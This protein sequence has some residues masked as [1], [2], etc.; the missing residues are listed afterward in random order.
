[1][2]SLIHRWRDVKLRAFDNAKHRTYVDLKASRA[3]LIFFLYSNTFFPPLKKFTLSCP[4]V[5]LFNSTVIYAKNMAVTLMKLFDCSLTVVFLNLILKFKSL[6]YV[7]DPQEQ[8]C[9]SIK[10]YSCLCHR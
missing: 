3:F 10:A 9:Y 7:L 4:I 2:F 8:K 5:L 1:M 6:L